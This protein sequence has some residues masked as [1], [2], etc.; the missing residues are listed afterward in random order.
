MTS[1]TASAQGL[2]TLNDL[3]RDLIEF[4]GETHSGR[5]ARMV[6]D[7]VEQSDGKP[8]VQM[9]EPMLQR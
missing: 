5:I 1:T 2:L 7:V 9:S 4:L 6:M 8:T 3:P